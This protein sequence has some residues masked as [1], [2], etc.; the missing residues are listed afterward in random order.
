M[1]H[2]FVEVYVS[3]GEAVLVPTGLVGGG[4]VEV[5]EDDAVSVDDFDGVVVEDDVHGFTDAAPA[6]VDQAAAHR[7]PPE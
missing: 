1:S 7:D 6:D 3:F 5:S 4:P 2:H